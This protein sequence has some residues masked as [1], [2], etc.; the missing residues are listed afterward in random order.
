M[1][2]IFCGVDW[3][4]DGASEVSVGVGVGE[5]D[6]DE[7]DGLAERLGLAEVDWL[8]EGVGE[9]NPD[10]EIRKPTSANKTRRI[11]ATRGHV[12]GLRFLRS[13]S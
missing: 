12:Q 4:G 11:N 10:W 8:G 7:D 3:V 6:V 2:L 1:M 13:G 5:D 9:K